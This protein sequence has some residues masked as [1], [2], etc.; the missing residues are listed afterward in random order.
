MKKKWMIPVLGFLLLLNLSAGSKETDPELWK[1]ALSIHDSAIVIDTH[2]DTPMAMIERDIDI[3]K[4]Q[5]STDV[6]LVRMREGGVDSSFFAV[7]V[8]NSRLP[9]FNRSTSAL[10]LSEG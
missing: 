3:G 4:I 5:A 8:S 6:D 9:L 7:Y 1:K 10:M 2:C